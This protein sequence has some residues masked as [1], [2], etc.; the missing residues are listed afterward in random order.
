M[1]TRKSETGDDHTKALKDAL[2]RA[3]TAFME[4]KELFR[5]MHAGANDSDRMIV[6]SGIGMRIAEAAWDDAEGARIPKQAA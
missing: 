4:C 5:A 3:E 6:L 1:R 2:G